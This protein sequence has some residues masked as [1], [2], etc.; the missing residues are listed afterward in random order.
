[1]NQFYFS[2]GNFLLWASALGFVGGGL[3]IKGY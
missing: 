1:M 2:E 3:G